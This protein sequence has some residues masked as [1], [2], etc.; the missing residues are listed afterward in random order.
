MGI[1]VG[2]DMLRLQSSDVRLMKWYGRLSRVP[3]WAWIGTF[4]I[5]AIPVMALVIFAGITL[6]L[7]GATVMAAVLVVGGILAII[8]K[9]MH[10]RPSLHDGRKNAQIVVRSTRVIDP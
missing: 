2:T 5:V 10:R 8:W 3:R 7:V 1:L 6:I 4:I 9:V